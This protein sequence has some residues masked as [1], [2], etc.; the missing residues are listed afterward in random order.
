[1][2]KGLTLSLYLLATVSLLAQ[3]Q[4]Q[5]VFAL[6][7]A[8][9]TDPQKFSDTYVLPYI[10]ENGLEKNRYAKSLLQDLKQTKPMGALQ[11]ADALTKVARYHA[12]DMGTTGSIGHE[13]TD[14]TPFHIRVRTQ[15]KAQ[16]MI[17]ENCAYG[18]TSALDFVMQL[19]I[20][21]G[22]ES[23]GHRKN[24]LEPKYQWIGI[25]IEPHKTYRTN[26]VMDFAERF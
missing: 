1:M 8:V 14:G 22:I 25:A 16:G 20:D 13:S 17:A 4:E 6:L 23:L 19:L 15:S 3:D 7:N 12:K 24:I 11:V 10:K 21:D 9:R 18:Q 26:C 5:E 2:I